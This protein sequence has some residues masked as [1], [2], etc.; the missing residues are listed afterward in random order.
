MPIIQMPD[1][2][3]VSFPDT[4]SREQITQLVYQKYPELN[5]QQ[6]K[7]EWAKRI[8][9]KMVEEGRTDLTLG[10]YA[11]AIGRGLIGGSSDL[12]GRL[13][14]GATFGGSDWLARKAGVNPTKGIEGMI[15]STDSEKV[16]GLIGLASGGVEMS[17]GLPTGG[18][19][20][21]G[22]GKGISAIPKA[23]RYLKYTTPAVSGAITG[24]AYGGFQ[25]DSAESAK[26]GAIRG[27][28]LGAGIDL[29]GRGLNAGFSAMQ[30]VK[31]VPRGLPNT[32]ESD[33]GTSIL[34]R[35]VKENKK[36]ARDVY[37]QAPAAKEQINQRM[38]DEF[39]R[40][41]APRIDVKGE[42]NAAKR[43]YGDYLEANKGNQVIQGKITP[44]EYRD[45]LNRWFN[46]SKVV[47][48]SGKPLKVYHGGGK[49]DK[50]KNSYD[51]T[52]YFT[53]DK[54]KADQYARDYLDKFGNKG[55]GETKAVYVNIKNPAPNEVMN[56]NTLDQV[57][58]QG[59]DG[60]IFNDPLNPKET[61]VR[62]FYPNQIK[63]VN[64]TG[65]FTKSAS[66]T[67]K[68]VKIVPKVSDIGINDQL[69][70]FQKQALN[71]AWNEGAMQLKKGEAIGSMKH[72]DY[73]KR[74]LNTQIQESMDASQT[75][76]GKVATDK[77][78]PLQELKTLLKET[79]NKAV[80]VEINQQY[81]QAKNLQNA[82]DQGLKFGANNI[83]TRDLNFSTNGE[84]SAFAQ[85][86][87]EKMTTNT[88]NTNISNSVLKNQ[89]VLKR[90]MP[91]SSFKELVNLARKNSLSYD[92]LA[93]LQSN[94]AKKMGAADPIGKDTGVIREWFDSILSPIGAGIDMARKVGTANLSGR[95]A[96]YLLNSEL[97]VKVP[98]YDTI[99]KYLPS[100]AVIFTESKTK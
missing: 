99:Q 69:S 6:E 59:Y 11:E 92:R 7:P 4:M 39:E 67:D 43:V 28:I 54:T 36:I 55:S 44:K 73:M 17:G 10:E 88:S 48:E 61:L 33:K 89:D 41:T 93:T 71:K 81:Q 5:K 86:L 25:G 79:T 66:L 49:F 83:K 24:G 34:N 94:A 97:P 2:Q 65:A 22:V 35:A 14:S 85:G 62:A 9:D 78:V 100:S 77:T 26:N 51:G 57:I 16:A 70:P 68:N 75:G 56:E 60:H 45:N 63:S 80:P 38:V 1:G 23:G 95:A 12:G 47:D 64:N 8:A 27:A 82:Y 52:Y 58:S 50:F 19:L 72:I 98:L 31:G 18:T 20:F 96:N 30:K 29:L 90:V 21:K 32:V 46:G 3:K 15:D 13:L 37:G 40:T 84:K 42:M 91:E 87:L 53:T 76:I 74:N